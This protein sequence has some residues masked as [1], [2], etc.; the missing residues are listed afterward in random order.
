MLGTAPSVLWMITLWQKYYFYSHF[1]IL[2]EEKSIWETKWLNH[3][4]NRNQTSGS[5]PGFLAPKLRTYPLHCIFLPLSIFREIKVKPLLV[6]LSLK[7]RTHRATLPQPS[8]FFWV[9][10]RCLTT[11]HNSSPVMWVTM[12]VR[13]Y[14]SWPLKSRMWHNE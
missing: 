13:K 8:N 11:E 1:Y 10:W 5:N 9:P 6:L 4:T 3:T 7:E 14:L 2:L 12:P